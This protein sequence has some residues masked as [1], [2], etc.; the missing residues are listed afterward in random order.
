[1]LTCSCVG[2]CVHIDRVT[3]ETHRLDAWVETIRCSLHAQNACMHARTRVFAGR[4]H[5]RNERGSKR[6]RDTNMGNTQGLH[7]HKVCT[8]CHG[9]PQDAMVHHGLHVMHARNA[10]AAPGYTGRTDHTCMHA[11]THAHTRVG[12]RT[13]T[14][15]HVS[16]TH[17][18]TDMCRSHHWRMTRMVRMPV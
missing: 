12:A 14:H 7:T 17:T 15:R 5:A 6:R 11:H 9:M 3:W 16:L 18:H 4:S 10:R 1:M 13:H 2:M 8:G